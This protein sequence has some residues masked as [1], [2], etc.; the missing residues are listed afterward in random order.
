M[1][2]YTWRNS[3]GRVPPTMLKPNPRGPLDRRVWMEYPCSSLGWSVNSGT[4]AEDRHGSGR[5][6]RTGGDVPPVSAAPRRP[7]VV[8]TVSPPH[9]LGPETTRNSVE[10]CDFSSDA[11]FVTQAYVA[12]RWRRLCPDLEDPA[13]WLS[14]SYD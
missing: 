6:T 1:T 8:I 13:S 2:L 14:L 11:H 10:P 5:G 12:C 4:T 3:L 9:F 7:A